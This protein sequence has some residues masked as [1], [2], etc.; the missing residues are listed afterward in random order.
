MNHQIQKDKQSGQKLITLKSDLLITRKS[1][2]NL[3]AN[4]LFYQFTPLE[5]FEKLILQDSTRLTLE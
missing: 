1:K 2:N 4:D 5:Y 3:K